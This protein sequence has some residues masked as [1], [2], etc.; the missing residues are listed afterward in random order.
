MPREGDDALVNLLGTYAAANDVAERGSFLL[1][2]EEGKDVAGV[3]AVGALGPLD[4]DGN[5]LAVE[6]DDKVHL[7]SVLGAI[8]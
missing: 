3:V 2:G 4:L 6:F 1:L 5:D 7:G 8:F